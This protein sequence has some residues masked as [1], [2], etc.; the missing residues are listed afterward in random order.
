MISFICPTC[1]VF[2]LPQNQKFLTT[3]L[4]DLLCVLVLLV[5]SSHHPSQSR[6][7]NKRNILAP[8]SKRERERERASIIHILCEL[9]MFVYGSSSFDL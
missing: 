1:N 5:A 8:V 7:N 6:L 3:A 2:E 9:Q 4:K